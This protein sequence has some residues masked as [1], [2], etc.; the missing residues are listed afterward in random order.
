MTTKNGFGATIGELVGGQKFER[1]SVAIRLRQKQE[2]KEV[3]ITEIAERIGADLAKKEDY[4]VVS[5]LAEEELRRQAGNYRSAEHE[6][7]LGQRRQ[8]VACNKNS[9]KAA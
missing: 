9:K 5:T 2:E 1:M 4:E 8:I 3:M 6:L 7:A